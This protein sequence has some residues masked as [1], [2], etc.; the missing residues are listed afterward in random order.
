MGFRQNAYARIWNLEKGKGNY[1]VADMSTSKK[2][3]N[4]EYVKDWA[5]KFVRLIGNAAKEAEK[6]SA[7]CNVRIGECDVTNHYDAEKRQ[8]Y[9]NYLIFTF[10]EDDNGGDKKTSA[11]KKPIADGDY[12]KVPEGI[13][14]ELPFT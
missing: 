1:M 10:A 8:T 2:D 13:D 12:I 6:M 11:K 9:T 5:N 14:E 4:G 3:A 7:P